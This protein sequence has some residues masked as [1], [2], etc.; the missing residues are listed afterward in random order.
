MEHSIKT[1]VTQ[2]LGNNGLT[3]KDLANTARVGLVS[4]VSALR[5]E[6]DVPPE[7]LSDRLNHRKKI[8]L[9]K[10]LSKLVSGCNADPGP[11]LAER[12]LEWI[13]LSRVDDVDR[14]QASSGGV[15]FADLMDKTITQEDL[16][17]ISDTIRR[18][19][20]PTVRLV[21]EL[22]RCRK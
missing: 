19:H 15:S 1:L 2:H 7:V 11:Y 10:T 9:A 3:Q 14:Q 22:L 4:I 18:L 12:S 17:L 5:G 21:L 20:K 13:G 16:D 6:Y 8:G